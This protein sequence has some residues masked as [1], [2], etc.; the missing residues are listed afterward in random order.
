MAAVQSTD[1]KSITPPRRIC[2]LPR[3]FSLDEA[4]PDPTG[5]AELG[6]GNNNQ[7]HVA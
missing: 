7:L 6:I 4:D 2:G 3:L 1:T 5:I